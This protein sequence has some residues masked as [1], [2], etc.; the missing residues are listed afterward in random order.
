MQAPRA[1]RVRASL[2]PTQPAA[3]CYDCGTHNPQWSSV[4]YGIWICLECS[5]K[6]R[7][8]GVHI[9][10]VRS[11]TMDKWKD[12]ELEKMKAGGNKRAREFLDAQADY[13]HQSSFQQKYNSVGAALYRDKLT[14]L[15]KGEPWSAETSSARNYQSSSAIPKS[16]STPTFKSQGDNNTSSNNGYGGYNDYQSGYQGGYQDPSIKAQT[17]NFF[18]RVQSENSSRSEHIPPSQGGKYAGFGNSNYQPPPKSA[19]TEF[20]DTAVSSLSSGW[21][22]LS[23]GASKA[24]TK[25]VEIGSKATECATEYSSTLSEKVKEGSL[26]EELGNQATTLTSKVTEVSRRGWNEASKVLGASGVS[27]GGGGHMALTGSNSAHE[28]SSLLM[29]PGEGYQRLD[30]NNRKNSEG[31]GDDGWTNDWGGSSNSP[32]WGGTKPQEQ[33][34]DSVANGMKKSS[35]KSKISN[36]DDQDLLVDVS[37][38]NKSTNIGNKGHTWDKWDDDWEKV[39]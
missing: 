33:S 23:I 22:L 13:D 19:S 39:E 12:L 25:A 24:A 9:S 31:W 11:I 34:S 7:G 8:L 5:G 27:G 10:F 16:T 26:L 4:S 37:D 36:K 28:R 30:S 1:G 14:H 6:H 35:S 3:Q 17:E 29:G 32:S 18:S 21:S 38:S 15:A 2:T 20:F